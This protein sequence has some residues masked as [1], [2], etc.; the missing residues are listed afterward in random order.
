M[1]IMAIRFT[2]VCL[3]FSVPAVGQCEDHLLAAFVGHLLVLRNNYTEM[4]LVFDSTGKLVSQ[5]TPGFGP[6]EGRFY[7]D[8]IM[9]EP[10][11]L[12]IVGNRP[13]GIY[14]ENR[15]ALQPVN[16][17]QQVVVEIDLPS[18]QPAETVVPN[19]LEKVFFMTAELD[20][21]KCS[22][23][24]ERRFY[25]RLQKSREINAK[26]VPK[27][28]VPVPDAQSLDAL[29]LACYPIG[30][31]AYAVGKGVKPPK[32]IKAPA[33]AFFLAAQNAK[34]IGI[35]DLMVIVDSNGKPASLI[36]SRPLGSGLDE[37]A[38]KAIRAWTFSPATFRGKPVPVAVNVE[39]NTK[40]DI[41]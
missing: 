2:L 22:A 6:N 24:V 33:D 37:E 4:H 3:L 29:Q 36:V 35:L 11:K 8:R 19:L 9:V 23:E 30:D 26:S 17:G 31:R 34:K 27:K 16:I 28:K 1:N 14:D 18:G 10:G 12:T 5:A 39:L 32:A 7:V 25:E 21:M 20:Q 40:P 15:K 38:A 41:R 13:I